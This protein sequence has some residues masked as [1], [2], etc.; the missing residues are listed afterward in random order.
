MSFDNN[1]PRI[2]VSRIHYP[3]F[4]TTTLKDI[5]SQTKIL[6]SYACSLYLGFSHVIRLA[7]GGQLQM[8]TSEIFIIIIDLVFVLIYTI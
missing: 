3:G 6:S 4:K 8:E 7:L 1:W 5:L 2:V